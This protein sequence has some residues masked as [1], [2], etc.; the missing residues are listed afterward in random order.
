MKELMVVSEVTT[1]GVGSGGII[2]GA[3]AATSAASGASATPPQ[4]L[5]ERVKD[6]GQ[7]GV[8]ALWDELSLEERDFLIRDIRSLDLAR[9]DR[10]IRCS[11]RS[12]GVPT[13][14][15]EPVPE[16]SVSKVEERTMEERARWW[17]MGLKAISEGR[18]GVLLLSGGQ[19]LFVI[20]LI[21]QILL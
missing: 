20:I 9:I 16:T 21:L 19:V 18:L 2:I 8:F 14:E 5:R 10:I 17:K 6:Y 15:I 13:P 4:D 7:D 1:N 11:F 3:A 12:Q